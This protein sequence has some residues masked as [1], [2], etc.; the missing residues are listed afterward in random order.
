MKYCNKSTLDEE[1]DE[2][3]PPQL[4]SHNSG[5]WKIQVMVI[6]KLA[7]VVFSHHEREGRAKRHSPD[8]CDAF[9]KTYCHY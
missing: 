2:Q 9:D 6:E 3:Q 8:F 5:S 4:I 1:A 7:F